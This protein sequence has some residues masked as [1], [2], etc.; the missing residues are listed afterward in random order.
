MKVL[1]KIAVLK[2]L[3]GNCECPYNRRM[4]LFTKKNHFDT[5]TWKYKVPL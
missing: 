5:F 2:H 4:K 3:L 1:L